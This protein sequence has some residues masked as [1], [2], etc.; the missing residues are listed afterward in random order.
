MRDDKLKHRCPKCGTAIIWHVNK[1]NA[2]AKG[3]IKCLNNISTSRIDWKAE[4]EII[5]EWEGLA[6]R[7]DATSFDFYCTSLEDEILPAFN[8]GKDSE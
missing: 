1:F 7:I 8:T 2:G 5:C 4:A 6:V 3:K